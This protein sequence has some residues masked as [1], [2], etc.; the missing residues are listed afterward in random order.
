V[1]S[2]QAEIISADSRQ[3]YTG[4]DI[5]TGK[6]IPS[7]F[8]KEKSSVWWRD[9][10]LS[11][12]TDGTTK[13]W[14]TDVV[15][16]HEPFN[17]AF[18]RECADLII[19]NI[20]LRKKRAWVV[21]GTG[22]YVRSLLHSLENTTIPPNPTLRSQL[23]GKDAQHLF[24]YLNRLDPARAASL[25]H[26]D[27]FNPR[28]LVRAIEVAYSAPPISGPIPYTGSLVLGLTA[29]KEVLYDRISQ[30]VHERMEQGAPQEASRLLNKYGT[31]L[32]SMSA[33]GYL[34]F[35]TANPQAH[36]ISTEH[37]YLRRQ[38]TWYKKQPEVS[39]FDVTA[40]G[41]ETQAKD[42]ISQWYN[43]FRFTHDT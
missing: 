42:A 1:D 7:H 22:L 35:T 4:M 31:Q 9:R 2:F 33:C 5:V 29:P 25:N 38:L 6:D 43:L 10:Y 30:R 8:I 37:A 15:Q 19:K 41:W 18:W 11:Y 34:S 27:R 28:R 3:V 36:W 12:Y 16:P 23:L 14:L 13:I 20:T 32:P 17:V 26:S 21:G 40:P 24:D 39:W